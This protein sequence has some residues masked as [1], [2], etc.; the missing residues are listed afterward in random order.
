MY[1]HFANKSLWLLI[2]ALCWIVG[3]KQYTVGVIHS[4]LDVLFILKFFQ[5]CAAYN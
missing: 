3:W 4:V 5:V 1:F 2:I